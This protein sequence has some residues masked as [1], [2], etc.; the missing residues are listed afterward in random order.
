[1]SWLASKSHH[2]VRGGRW[3]RGSPL[4]RLAGRYY[5]DPG[6]YGGRLGLRLARRVS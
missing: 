1:M 3:D 6:N 4:A 5:G 2:V